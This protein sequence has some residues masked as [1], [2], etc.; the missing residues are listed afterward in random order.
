MK[1]STACLGS[2]QVRLELTEEQV[3]RIKE[4]RDRFKEG[5]SELKA[6]IREKKGELDGLFRDPNA[7]TDEIVAGRKA[8]FDLK[9]KM[10]EMAMD[11][12]LKIRAELTADQ[13][14]KLPEGSWRGLLPSGHGCKCSREKGQGHTCPYKKAHPEDTPT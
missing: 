14:G 6:A 13:I 10:G 4:I 11:F 9:E 8:L 2:L 5:S 12:R 3:E 7:G 1:A